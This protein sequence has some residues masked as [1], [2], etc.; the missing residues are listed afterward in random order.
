MRAKVVKYA[1]SWATA[2][3]KGYITLITNDSSGKPTGRTPLSPASPEEFICLL[4][5]L[6]NEKPVFWDDNSATLETGFE[7]TGEGEN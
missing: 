5:I 7:P 6:R 2:Q 4:D 3:R 1:I